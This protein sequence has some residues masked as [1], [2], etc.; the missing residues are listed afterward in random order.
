MKKLRLFLL[1]AVLGCL[2]F[3]GTVPAAASPPDTVEGY[4]EYT[5]YIMDS[6]AADGNTILSTTEDTDWY[7]PLQ[8]YSYDV[9]TVIVHPSGSM[10]YNAIGYFVGTVDGKTGTLEML[11]RGILPAGSSSWEGTWVILSGS[12]ELENLRG[13]GTFWGEGYVGEGPGW[14]GYAGKIHFVSE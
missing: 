1:L 14:I 3:V 6:R 10:I 13:Q 4:F 2:L 12:G 7:G 5:P 9:C 11:L 8:G